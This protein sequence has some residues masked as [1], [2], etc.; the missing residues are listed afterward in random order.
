[1]AIHY[2]VHPVRYLLGSVQGCTPFVDTSW[3]A[4]VLLGMWPLIMYLIAAYYR[5][6]ASF[7]LLK[8]RREVSSILSASQTTK[9]WYFRLFI[10]AALL[11]LG[12]L[13]L[14]IAT[15][16]FN[17]IYAM[18]PYDWYRV[19]PPAWRFT[20]QRLIPNKVH[21]WFWVE[22]DRYLQIAG[23]YMIFAF[24]GFCDEAKV[25]YK[26]CFERLGIAKLWHDMMEWR[27][28]KLSK[29]RQSSSDS[30]ATISNSHA[31]TFIM[32]LKDGFDVGLA[33]ISCEGA[34]AAE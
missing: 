8:N 26:R 5:G 29:S 17:A 34:R 18:R 4:F 14:Y 27:T 12:N 28:A 15:S 9:S 7:R 20:I 23:V 3:V 2:I 33:R 1:M 10:L 22:T 16:L 32:V 19:H 25:L 13:P 21:K 6:L 30:A 31:L 24:F 11:V